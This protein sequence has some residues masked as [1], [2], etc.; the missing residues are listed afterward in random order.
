MVAI[1]LLLG[2]SYLTY[3]LVIHTGTDPLTISELRS[4]AGALYDQPVS[5]AGTV[6]P[7]SVDWDDKAKVMRFILTDDRENLTVVYEGI[8]P[9]SFKP[10]AELIVAGRYRP[11]DVFEALSIGRE[12][13]L[14]N[15]CH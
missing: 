8:A 3:S 2:L 1:V 6:A 13:S 14:C 12:G 10:G 11:D 5:V 15:A 7:G 4:K 9:D